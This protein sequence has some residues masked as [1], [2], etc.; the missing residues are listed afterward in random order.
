MKILSYLAAAALSL[1][2]LCSQAGVIY[3]W[4]ATNDETP[5]GITLE[6][7]FD[8]ATVQAGTLNYYFEHFNDDLPPPGLLNLRYTFPG[9]YGVQW[10]LQDGGFESQ[11]GY[12]D[13]QLSFGA[14]GFLSGSIYLNDS[15]SHLY[16]ES[17]GRTFTIVDANSDYEMIEAGCPWHRPEPCAGATGYLAREGAELPAEVPEPATLALFGAGLLAAARLRRKTVR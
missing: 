16:M 7:E 12:I 3:Q 6:L 9:P 15:E 13:L 11:L 1:L 8:E 2:P 17:V 10:S 5:Y 4:Q 14:D